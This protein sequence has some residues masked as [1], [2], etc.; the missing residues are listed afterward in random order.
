MHRYRLRA[1]LQLHNLADLAA[2][3]RLLVET[4]R[5]Q[6]R[7]GGDGTRGWGPLQQA[8]RVADDF[9]LSWAGREWIG[10]W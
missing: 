5:T 8:A 1:Y 7:R 2:D 4:V 9:V 6:R 3:I 10:E